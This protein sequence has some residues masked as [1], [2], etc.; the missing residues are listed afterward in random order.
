MDCRSNAGS[1]RFGSVPEGVHE[2]I[3]LLI[4]DDLEEL[5]V[6]LLDALSLTDLFD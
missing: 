2:R 6:C 5:S 4:P 3:A 1:K